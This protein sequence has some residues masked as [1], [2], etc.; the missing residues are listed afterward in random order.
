MTADYV[1]YVNKKEVVS[2]YVTT[3]DEN[4]DVFLFTCC[5]FFARVNFSLLFAKIL[6]MQLNL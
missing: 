6:K 4:D 3:D 2:G 5:F 1:L